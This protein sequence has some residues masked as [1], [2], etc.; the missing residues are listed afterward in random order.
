MSLAV[1]M[2]P[3]SG[4]DRTNQWFSTLQ[5]GFR[6]ALELVIVLFAIGLLILDFV[7]MFLEERI[8]GN[9]TMR[10]KIVQHY[11]G[12]GGIRMNKKVAFRASQ[13]VILTSSDVLALEAP[14]EGGTILTDVA[15]LWA[16]PARGFATFT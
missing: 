1:A 14:S 8:M 5:G 3:A 2:L 10:N 16:L 4:L 9:R 11:F 15:M 13:A 7:G 6:F 12:F